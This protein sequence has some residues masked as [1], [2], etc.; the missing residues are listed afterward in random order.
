MRGPASVDDGERR[1]LSLYFPNY[2]RKST[3]HY[4]D[5]Q[6]VASSAYVKIV[7]TTCVAEKLKFGLFLFMEV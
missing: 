1:M 7:M 2:S 3:V 4:D 5:L 6:N